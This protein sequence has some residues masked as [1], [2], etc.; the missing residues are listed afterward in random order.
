MNIEN[1]KKSYQEL[2]DVDFV[3]VDDLCDHP[4]HINAGKQ[5]RKGPA[6]RNILKHKGEIFVCRECHMKYDNPMNYVGK[7]RQ[8]DEEITV[9][10]PHPDHEGNP[11][12]IMK[13]A[14]YFG[15]MQ[16]PYLQICKSCA[17]LGKEIPDEQREKIRIA[18][19]GI[20]RSEEFKQKLSDYMKNNPEGISRATKNIIENHCTTGMLGKTH[21]DEVRQKMSISHSGKIFTEEHC[22]KISE[23]RKKMLEETGGFTKEHRENLSKAAARQY[24]MGFDP[25]IHHRKGWHTS[26]KAG[27]IFYRSSYEKRAYLILDNDDLVKTYKTENIAISYYNP[28]KEIEAT[29]FID[30]EVIMVD[31]THKL[32]EIKPECW[33]KDEVV[34]AKI[35]HAEAY[36]YLNKMTFEVW[37]EVQLFGPVYNERNMRKFVEE[38]DADDGSGRKQRSRERSNKHYHSKIS[39]DTI[40]FFCQF[41]QEEHTALRKT[42]EKNIERNQRYIC[43]REG[44]KIAGS[45]PKKKKINPYAA[46]GKKQ[47]NQ[48]KGIKLFEEFS[49]DKSKTDGYS[50]RCKSCRAEGYR[51]KY[52]GKKQDN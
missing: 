21:S 27:K 9:Y 45:K 39:T 10:C 50:T 8:T 47:C 52:Q 4:S 2:R 17:Q 6:K 32:I 49:P 29:Y 7:G 11:S 33:C 48:C 16:E 51:L 1:F 12:R 44:G 37:T 42:Y 14:C 36:A 23:G 13:K 31:G 26:P 34:C 25:K 40:T 30:L 35:E 41:C 28:V 38:L 15:N 20:S 22:Q 46:D 5:I 18:L 24:A 43:E 19:K 3:N